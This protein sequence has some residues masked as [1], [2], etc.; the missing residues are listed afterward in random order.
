[1]S[2]TPAAGGVVW[3]CVLGVGVENLG[4]FF[5]D[6]FVYLHQFLL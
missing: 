5:C 2:Q 6:Y 1:M 4:L 3:V